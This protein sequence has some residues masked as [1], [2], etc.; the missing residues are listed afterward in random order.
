[1]Y[2]Y[3][4]PKAEKNPDWVALDHQISIN[5]GKDWK[6]TNYKDQTIYICKKTERNSTDNEDIVLGV[7]IRFGQ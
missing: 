6:Q 5:T 7:V 2:Y 3:M 1:M 4:M